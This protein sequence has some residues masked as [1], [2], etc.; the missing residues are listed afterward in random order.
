MKFK[1]KMILAVVISFLFLITTTNP[2][3]AATNRYYPQPSI[4]ITIGEC[5]WDGTQSITEVTF[6]ATDTKLTVYKPSGESFPVTQP[7]P[8]R[9]AYLPS[10]FY[11]YVWWDDYDPTDFTNKTKVEGSFELLSCVPQASVTFT[12][13]ECQ[14]DA[15]NGSVTPVTIELDHAELTLNGVFYTT[16]PSSVNLG[17]GDYSYSWSPTGGYQGGATNQTLT[18]GNCNPTANVSHTPGGCVYNG[19]QSTT[20]VQF[21]II[22]AD[23]VVSG[24]SGDVYYPTP[25]SPSLSLPAGFYTYT[26]DVLPHYN[27][28]N[29]SRSFTLG[30]CIPASVSY[31]I[32]ECNWDTQ[33]PSRDLSFTVS[34]ATVTLS[35]P[36][37][38]YQ[39]FAANKI[40][41]DLSSGNYSFD[42]LANPGYAGSGQVDLELPVCQPGVATVAVNFITCGFDDQNN[43]YGEVA[44]SLTGSELSI[45][46]EILSE[47]TM[48]FLP[49]AHYDF[50][51]WAKSGFEGEGEGEINT[52]ICAPK[53]SPEVRVDKG[54]CAIKNGQSLTDV[55][56]VIS[57]AE[58]SLTNSKGDN[59]GPYTSSQTIYLPPGEYHYKWTSTTG[60][61]SQGGGKFTITACETEKESDI[62]EKENEVKEEEIVDYDP[63][64]D[65]PAG[66]VGPSLLSLMILHFSVALIFIQF[67]LINKRVVH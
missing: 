8:P 42:W 10:G 50:S 44:V 9:I 47:T 36:G 65:Y 33:P 54:S 32:G 62:Q 4:E 2:C 67:I 13:G 6:S 37:V 12:H 27:G 59:F 19:S 45:N 57:G 43:P 18:V 14:W 60:D 66:G 17:P 7:T 24:S 38:P 48:L 64:P 31:A 23:V 5:Q 28:Q 52:E 22:G 51:W 25:T 46:G 11:D 55:S 34:G 40:F 16:S 21:N 63:T 56:L 58:L 35:S 26:W 20:S 39:P 53:S 30:T 15:T 61:G 41:E 1:K 49:P 3:L 29:E